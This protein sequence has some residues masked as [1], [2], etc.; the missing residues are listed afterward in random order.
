[1]LSLSLLNFNWITFE[2]FKCF[3]FSSNLEEKAIQSFHFSMQIVRTVTSLAGNCNC[4]ISPNSLSR[5]KSTSIHAPLNSTSKSNLTLNSQPH[6]GRRNPNEQLQLSL[7]KREH[8]LRE[9]YPQCEKSCRNVSSLLLHYANNGLFAEAQS[10]C[11]EILYSSFFAPT[12]STNIDLDIVSSLIQCYAQMGHFQDILPILDDITSRNCTNNEI[13]QCVYSLAVSCFG[14]AGLLELMEETLYKMTS[15]G[16]KIDS[17]TGNTFVKYYSCHGSIPDMEYVYQRLKKSRI[18]I[19]KDTIRAMASK[20]IN[21]RKYFKL[22]EFVKDVGLGRLNVGNLLWN[23]LL[24]SYA[25]NFKMKTLQREFLNM[26][27][28]GFRPDLNTFNIRA[29]AF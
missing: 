13:S 15:K 4:C 19:E 25:V 21:E 26:L 29:L 10:L 28:N 24:L 22:G 3:L 2:V 16:L 23:L 17:F 9:L 18:L 8:L 27:D 6:Q 14:K 5:S 1:M 11:D 12:S 20:Y 7:E